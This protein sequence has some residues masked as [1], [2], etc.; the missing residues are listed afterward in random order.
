MALRINPLRA[1]FAE[2]MA[3][4]ADALSRLSG[5][6]TALKDVLAEIDVNPFLVGPSGA[7]G[8]A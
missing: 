7:G 2:T 6:A 5:L 3:S 8:V 4:F 1:S